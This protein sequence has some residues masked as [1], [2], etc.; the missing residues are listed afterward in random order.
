MFSTQFYISLSCPAVW[1]CYEF[2][3]AGRACLRTRQAWPK[4]PPPPWRGPRRLAAVPHHGA[5]PAAAA[6][7]RG[8][9]ARG[10]C[11]TAVRT[12]IAK[13]HS[14]LRD[15]EPP[16]PCPCAQSD[17][18]VTVTY[19]RSCHGSFGDDC[20]LV[21]PRC[22]GTGCVA[23]PLRRRLPLALA[24]RTATIA[25]YNSSGRRSKHDPWHD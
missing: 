15:F 1:I 6:S 10:L 23:A 3:G 13:L 17:G 25:V 16:P 21:R 11:D 19:D 2:W 4:R 8:A 9:L 7:G 20:T 18:N 14:P 12:F 5:Q 22:L 24:L